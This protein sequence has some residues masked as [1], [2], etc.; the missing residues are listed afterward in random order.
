MKQQ[1]RSNFD[2]GKESLSYLKSSSQRK[3]GFR[4]VGSEKYYTILKILSIIIIISYNNTYFAVIHFEEYLSIIKEE[5]FKI[6][7]AYQVNI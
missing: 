5:L 1:P 2:L 7:Y 3:N 4:I 6:K